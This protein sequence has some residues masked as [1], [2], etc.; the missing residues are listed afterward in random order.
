MDPIAEV[1]V[2]AELLQHRIERGDPAALARLQPAR[3]RTATPTSPPSVE[4]AP[5][6]VRRKH[7]LSAVARELGFADYAHLLRVIDGDPAEADFGTLPCGRAGGA[8]LNTWYPRYDEAKEHQRSAG[9]TLLAYRR[10]FVLV[11]TAYIRDVV[12]IDPEHPDWQAIAY[13][14]PRPAD[15]AARRRLYGRLFAQ[16][17]R[18]GG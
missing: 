14:W 3:A 15:L 9:G 16:A 12:G 17:P 1:K 13:D 11:G 6:E 2:R 8:H 5:T 18:L 7:C 4:P 10:H